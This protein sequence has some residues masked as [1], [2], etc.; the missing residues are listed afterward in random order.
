MD[1]Y[2]KELEK[3]EKRRTAGIY[4][5]LGN[6]LFMKQEF[7]STLFKTDSQAE[8][9]IFH[10]NQNEDVAFLDNLVSFGLFAS[11]KILVYYDIDKF[12]SKYRNKV[13]SYISKPDKMMTL[14]FTAEKATN[15][16]TKDIVSKATH[17]KVWTPFP[18]QYI[19]FVRKQIERLGMNATGE[20]INLLASM[21]NDSLYHTFA[22]F[23]KVLINTGANRKITAED[24]K[25][26]VGGEK[27][28]SIWDFLDA[29][30]NKNFYKAIEICESLVQMGT[31]PP[32]FIMSLY[33]F[34]SDMYVCYEED[35]NKLFGY[36][37][38]KKTQ[39][40]RSLGNYRDANFGKI[41][42]HLADS[43]LKSKSTGLLTEELIVPLIYEI[44]NA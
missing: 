30:G 34:F 14:I 22:E 10:A 9:K 32:F 41:F 7:V 40:S 17:V 3:I 37:W 44:I 21:T 28:Y 25:K 39:I 5:L 8:K 20:A 2:F 36:N 1:Q 24:V 18:N 13:L 16:F 11:R 42:H 19:E 43:D 31:P 27:K 15:N 38:Q 33:N 4:F 23:E 26:V 6:D 29:V 35:V 12:T